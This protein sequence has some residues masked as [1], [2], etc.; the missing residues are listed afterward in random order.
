M[1]TPSEWLEEW[2]R[3]VYALDDHTP[4]ALKEVGRQIFQEAQTEAVMGAFG[5]FK[6]RAARAAAALALKA[7]TAHQAR[8]EAK[9]AAQDKRDQS[10]QEDDDV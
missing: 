5:F 1:K 3:R 6:N 9:H 4:E 2:Q 10:T 7:W 8:A